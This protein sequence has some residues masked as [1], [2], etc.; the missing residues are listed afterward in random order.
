V[1]EQLR[2]RAVSIDASAHSTYEKMSE[3]TKLSADLVWS[4]EELQA[5]IGVFKL[6]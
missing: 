3:Q 5:A 4:A 1:A 2:F 6:S